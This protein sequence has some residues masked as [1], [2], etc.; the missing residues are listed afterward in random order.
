M[1]TNTNRPI[2]ELMGITMEKIKEM[3]DINSIIGDPITLDNGTTIIPISKVS[4]GFASGGS[5]LPNKS[6]KS[7][8]GG[9][10]GA[11][12]S[13]KPEGFLVISGGEPKFVPVTS[14]SDPVSSAINA[15]PEVFNKVSSMVKKKKNGEADEENTETEEK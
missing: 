7:L 10:V 8:F 9:G 3:V 15:I 1:N 12:V 14:S 5:D 13:I 6:E 11:G 4:Y 2:N